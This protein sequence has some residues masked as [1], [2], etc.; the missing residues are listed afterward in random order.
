MNKSTDGGKYNKPRANNQRNIEI[1][2]SGPAGGGAY[3][4]IRPILSAVESHFGPGRPYPHHFI[5]SVSASVAGSAIPSL[6]PTA[7]PIPPAGLS[8]AVAA[9]SAAEFARPHPKPRYIFYVTYLCT[10]MIFN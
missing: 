2:V 3:S 8:S 10:M 4:Q 5:G 9:M 1:V 6:L 7:C